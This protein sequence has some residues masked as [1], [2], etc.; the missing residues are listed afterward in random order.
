MMFFVHRGLTV[1]AE[2]AGAP[3][4]RRDR[5]DVGIRERDLLFRRG[6]LVLQTTDLGCP[7]NR[8]LLPVGGAAD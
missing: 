7:G 2:H 3:T 1:I 4:A 6:D 5:A 8:W